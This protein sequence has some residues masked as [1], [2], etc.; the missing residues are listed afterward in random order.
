MLIPFLFLKHNRSVTSDDLSLIALSRWTQLHMK[1]YLEFDVVLA[2]YKSFVSYIDDEIMA[3]S[4]F[5][6]DWMKSRSK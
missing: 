4:S 3:S 1:N 6:L 5:K 2:M